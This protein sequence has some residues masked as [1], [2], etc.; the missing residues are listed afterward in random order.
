MATKAMKT[1]QTT[2]D[3]SKVATGA[4][5]MDA[6]KPGVYNGCINRF[7]RALMGVARVSTF[8]K[9]KYGTWDGW[10]AVEDGFKR[11]MDAGARHQLYAAMGEE[12]DPDSGTLLH[13]EQVA[14]NAL[15]TLELYLREK[16]KTGDGYDAR[17]N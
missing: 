2:D 3:Q 14:W 5:K 6:G 7:P 1:E 11:Y 17:S 8:G 15:A 10:E 9:N 16:E 4:F 13:L 12:I